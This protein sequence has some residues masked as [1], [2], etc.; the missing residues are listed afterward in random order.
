MKQ[1]TISVVTPTLGRPQEVRDL[2]CNLSGQTCLPLEL[3]LVDGADVVV[4]ETEEIVHA[5]TATLPFACHYIRR[6]G[7]T[8]VQ[9]NAGIEAATGDFVAFVDD[10]IRL[11]PDYFGV[12][13]SLFAK[14]QE[15]RIGG[16]T[17]YISNAHLDPTTS[18]RWK[19]YR[20]L[21]LFSTYVPGRYDYA[22]GYPINRYL[23]PPHDGVREIDVMGAGCA[24]WR[25]QVFDSGLR[26]A[27]FFIGHGVL[28]DAHLALRARRHWT[29][30]ESGRARCIHLK[31]P[32]ARE[33]FRQT[34]RKSA[35]NYRHVFVDIVP[36]RT[37]KQEARFWF[38]QVFDLFRFT[39]AALRGP[40]RQGWYTV[41]GKLEGIIAALKIRPG[42]DGDGQ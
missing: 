42:R 7:G 18:P 41:L 31:S 11:E 36:N 9:R 12:I 35:T 17:G 29:L 21:R 14:D 28:E 38:I 2:L 8:A 27:P 5:Q 3:I 23:Q 6:G 1:P 40:N 32:L 13:L 4:K 22:T 25:R 20:R 10:D 33:D 26:F 37:W 24:V 39:V 15:S 16:I 19:W 30:L 34:A